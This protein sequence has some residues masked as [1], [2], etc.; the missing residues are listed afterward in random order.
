MNLNTRLHLH[1]FCSVEEIISSL[2]TRHIVLLKQQNYFFNFNNSNK[3]FNLVVCV[4]FVHERSRK[5]SYNLQE[6][7]E[8]RDPVGSIPTSY[9]GGSWIEYRPWDGV[10]YSFPQSLKENTGIEL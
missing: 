1:D 5:I 7:I 4:L 9:Q 3:I 10:S 2:I 6:I 8:R